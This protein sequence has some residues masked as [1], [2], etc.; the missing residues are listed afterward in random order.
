MDGRLSM[1]AFLACLSLAGCRTDR[2][3]AAFAGADPG[4]PLATTASSRARSAAPSVVVRRLWSG[5][6]RTFDF[7]SVSPDGRYLSMVDWSTIDLAV[8]DLGT[9]ELHRLTQ[10]PRSGEMPYEDAGSSVFSRDGSRLAYTWQRVPLVQLRVMDVTAAEGGAIRAGEPD[11]VFSNPELEPYFPFDWSPDG[12]TILA[13]T[14]VAGGQNHDHNANQLAF[15]STTDGSY[16][17]LRTF[18]WREP[19]NAAYS[20][21]GRF[22][23]YDFLPD[24]DSPDRDLFV[25]SVDGTQEARVVEGP[26]NDRLMGWHPDG[27]IL[28]HSDRDGTP[29]LWRLP[30]RDGRATAPPELLQSDLWNVQPLGFAGDRF[31]YGVDVNPPRLYTASVDWTEGRLSTVPEPIDDPAQYAVLGWD[32]AP[33]GERLAYSASAPGMGGSILGIRSGKAGDVRSLRVDLAAT[34]RIRWQPDGGSVVLLTTDSR[35]RRGFFQIHPESG[36][37]EPLLFIDQLNGSTADNANFA[38][39]ADGKTLYFAV[40]GDL[41]T[42]DYSMQLV[43]HDLRTG[44]TTQIGT[45]EWPGLVAIDSS[46]TRLAFVA[47]AP[48]ATGTDTPTSVVT[49]QPLEGGSPLA[50]YPVPPGFSVADLTWAL[51]GRSLV[52]STA[53]YGPGG[54]KEV[55]ILEVPLTGGATRELTL[56]D[57]MQPLLALH[58]GG[59]EV[60]YMAGEARGEVWVMDGLAS[61]ANASRPSTTKG[62]ASDDAK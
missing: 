56:A 10:A 31:Y 32:W 42:P 25:V 13:K 44:K 47:I 4:P 19:L 23:A 30:I 27:S 11:I 3:P 39:S 37:H 55:A 17:P 18:D 35:G 28:F 16:R 34:H 33:D 22:F 40:I 51:D 6:Y 53:R 61:A 26:A 59:R 50:L 8:R 46:Q 7:S 60:A 21:D 36:T 41:P 1:L 2:D 14:W 48:A 12:R 43:S 62:E 38:L 49:V 9:G 54:L 5:G 29:G 20:P 45:A 58:P 24:V 15:I 57:H 52:V